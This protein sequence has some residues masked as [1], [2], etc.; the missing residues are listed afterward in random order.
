MNTRRIS[1]YQTPPCN[2]VLFLQSSATVCTKVAADSGFH[3]GCS[4]WNTHVYNLRSHHIDTGQSDGLKID[5]RCLTPWSHSWHKPYS[6]SILLTV[7]VTIRY[8]FYKLRSHDDSLVTN[9][10]D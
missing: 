1:Y 2:N 7:Q 4:I 5:L 10:P 8:A 3:M 6:A 9:T